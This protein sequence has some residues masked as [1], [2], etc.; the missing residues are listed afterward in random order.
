MDIRKLPADE[1]EK[2]R[3]KTEEN[4]KHLQELKLKDEEGFDTISYKKGGK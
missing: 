2:L 3:K 1:L 4:I